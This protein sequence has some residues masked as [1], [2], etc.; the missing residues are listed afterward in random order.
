MKTAKPT[1]TTRVEQL[2][3]L[4]QER[5]GQAHLEQIAL[6]LDTGKQN[7]Q[8]VI[9][10]GVKQGLVR[11][12]GQRTGEVALV[13]QSEAPS[14]QPAE[15]QVASRGRS[16][17]T[18]AEQ[19]VAFLREHDGEAHITEI[20]EALGTSALNAR[21]CIAGAV[22][23]GL[24]QRVGSRTGRVALATSGDEQEEARPSVRPEDLEG[25]Q[26]QVNDALRE[27]GRPVTAKEIASR[28]GGRPREAGNALK[29]LVDVGLARRD[30]DER[31]AKYEIA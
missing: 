16:G 18:R 30:G 15:P 7:A 25:F 26:R 14:P 12:L 31:P 8:N 6:V 29:V 4:L 3:A 23:Q 2:V 22:K 13:V 11:R 5:G 28:L 10:A 1:G 9:A 27:V 19:V 20:A 17:T 21:N 24:V